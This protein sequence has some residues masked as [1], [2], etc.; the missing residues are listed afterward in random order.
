[1]A[2]PPRR[3]TPV[4]IEISSNRTCVQTGE[5]LHGRPLVDRHIPTWQLTAVDH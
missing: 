4:A 2:E 5:T 3:L 1:M